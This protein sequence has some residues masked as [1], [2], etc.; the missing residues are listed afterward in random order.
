M[1][2]IISDFNH[3]QFTNQYS[4]DKTPKMRFIIV[5]ALLVAIVACAEQHKDA[6]APTGNYYSCQH[7]L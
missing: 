5:L 6:P 4:K 7:S 3:I 1:K 2:F